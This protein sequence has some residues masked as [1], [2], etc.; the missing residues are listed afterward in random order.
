[1][2]IGIEIELALVS[3]RVLL[4]LLFR[5]REAEAPQGVL[6][7]LLV[8]VNCFRVR[9]LSFL[10]SIVVGRSS[11]VF[12][13]ASQSAPLCHL[14]VVVADAVDFNALARRSSPTLAFAVCRRRRRQCRRR[15]SVGGEYSFVYIVT[16]QSP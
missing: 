14:M 1:M 9:H 13:F 8:L 15:S 3:V 5:Q 4:K 7:Q 12:S 11:I 2:D 16:H 6:Q 10:N